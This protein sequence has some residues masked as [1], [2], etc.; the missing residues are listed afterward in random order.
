M[1]TSRLIRVLSEITALLDIVEL[2]P[3]KTFRPIFA[4]FETAADG[5]IIDIQFSKPKLWISA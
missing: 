3:I 1:D 5:W 4:E 2:A